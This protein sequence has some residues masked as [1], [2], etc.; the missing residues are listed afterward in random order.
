[1]ARQSK[2]WI[3][4]GIEVNKD[5]EITSAN[6]A[7][8]ILNISKEEITYDFMMSTFGSFEGK[9]KANTYDLV[10]VPVGK[11]SFVD[12][13]GKTKS[14][15]NEFTTSL[16]IFIF[17]ILLSSFNFS[18][19]FVGYIN[20]SIDSKQYKNIGQRL[21]YALIEDEISVEDLKQWENTMQWLMPFEDILS[22]NHTEKLIGCTKAL[23]KKKAELIKK[24]Q[25]EIDAGDIAVVE[26]IEKELLA[27]AKEYLG[28]D[29]AMDTILSGAGGQFNNNFKNMFVMKGAIRNPDPN[30]KK[31]YDIVTSNYLDGISAD[32]YSIIAGSGASG[33][34]SRG[35]KTETGG[36][37][38]KLFV[39]AYQHIQLDAKGSDCG[40]SRHIIVDLNEKNIKDYMYCYAIKA[41]GDLELIDSKTYKNYIGKRAKLRFSSMCE[42]KTGICNKCAGQL[43]YIG[44]ENIGMTMAQIPSTLKLKCMKGF[45][46]STVK[47]TQFD[48]MKAFFPFEE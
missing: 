11:F 31:K 1:M 24:Y 28:D 22:P 37:W 16:G 9:S 20:K 2:I 34:Y 36:Y 30:A 18:K 29:P 40:T 44:A 13:N 14:N 47:T 15:K 5:D 42:S 21:S 43:L 7:D 26:S 41:N 17:N 6:L 25:K 35:K 19:F 12:S 33:A 4:K 3:P 10:K 39:S 38:E 46:D 45:H 8:Y 23:N 48:P 27:Y 32:E